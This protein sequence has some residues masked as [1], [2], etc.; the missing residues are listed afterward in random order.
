MKKAFVIL[1]ILSVLFIAV[2]CKSTPETETVDTSNGV[3]GAD[4]TPRPDWVKTMSKKTADSTHY[5]VGYGKMSTY[6]TSLKRAEADGRNKIALWLKADVKTVL[7]TYTQDAGVAG[8][9]ELIE[10][11]EEVSKQT[12][13]VSISGAEVE[14]S[15]ED[16]EHGVYILMSYDVDKA[17]ANLEKAIDNTAKSFNRKETAAFAEFKATEALKQLNAAS[18]E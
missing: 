7:N 14:D 2:G 4:G 1:M 9:S 6:A 5:E 15:W 3:V 8:D 16:I 18:A 13:E 10:F 17:A 12:A 11:M